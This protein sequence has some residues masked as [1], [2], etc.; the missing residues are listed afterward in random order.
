MDARESL[1]NKIQLLLSPDAQ[2]VGVGFADVRM[3]AADLRGVVD[4]L[5][6]PVEKPI[7]IRPW[8]EQNIVEVV[9]ATSAPGI[10]LIDMIT[11]NPS[12]PS[13]TSGRHIG[14]SIEKVPSEAVEGFLQTFTPIPSSTPV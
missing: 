13:T 12:S 8:A 14:F 11:S 3:P 10:F 7:G 1:R 5:F 4:A 9:H 2:R 6:A